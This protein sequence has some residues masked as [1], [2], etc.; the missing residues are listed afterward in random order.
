MSSLKKSKL[1]LIF[2]ILKL[3]IIFRS[4]TRFFIHEMVERLES[5]RSHYKCNYFSINRQDKNGDCALIIICKQGWINL[6]D[7]ISTLE[8][9][10]QSL[11]LCS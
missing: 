5:D 3:E 1:N 10:Y 2:K 7:K 4:K 8:V 9:I 6:L 11:I